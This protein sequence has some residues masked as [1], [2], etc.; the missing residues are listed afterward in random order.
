[1][2]GIAAIVVVMA[3]VLAVFGLYIPIE[4]SVIIAYA[5][6]TAVSIAWKG[7]T[8]GGWLCGHRVMRRDGR[9][10]GLPRSLVRALAV[11]ASQCLLG[12]PFLVIA[13]KRSKYGWHD[14]IA[15]TQVG[16]LEHGRNRRRWTAA[17]VW[18]VVAGGLAVQTVSDWRLYR[19]HSAWCADA[20]AAVEKRGAPTDSPIEVSSLDGAQRQAMT[21]WLADHSQS[22]ADCVV[23]VAAR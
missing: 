6:Y 5:A 15:R 11:S 21:D 8:L 2:G 3:E 20:D 4:L 1:M 14:S 22:P 7:Q 12:L 17:I 10:V 9:K 13:A 19:V 23:G 18:L 16:V